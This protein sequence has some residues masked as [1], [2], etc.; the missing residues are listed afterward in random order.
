MCSAKRHVRFTPESGHCLRQGLDHEAPS[1]Q[2]ARAAESAPATFPSGPEAPARR[3]LSTL[4]RFT[5]TSLPALDPVEVHEHVAD[6]SLHVTVPESAQGFFGPRHDGQLRCHVL[7]KFPPEPSRHEAGDVEDRLQLLIG[8]AERGHRKS[9]SRRRQDYIPSPLSVI[10]RKSSNN[11]SD[12]RTVRS[13]L[14]AREPRLN[15]HLRCL[16]VCRDEKNDGR[17]LEAAGGYCAVLR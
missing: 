14:L 9:Y 5:S 2:S 12:L 13:P 10:W 6:G 15:K 1:P 4:S 11:I 3:P 7:E 8:E 16:L 17:C